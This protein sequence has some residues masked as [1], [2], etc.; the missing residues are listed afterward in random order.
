MSKLFVTSVSIALLV[1]SGSIHAD[2]HG[3]MQAKIDKL[4]QEKSFLLKRLNNS[5]AY[6]KSRAAQIVELQAKADSEQSNRKALS[7]R[8]NNAV[9]FSKTRGANLEAAQAMAD[10]EQR[11]STALSKRLSN[12]IAFSKTR[13]AKLEAAQAMADSEQRKS[14]ALSKRLSNAIA[15]SKTRGAK[16]AES[17]AMAESEKSKRIALSK[18]LSNAIAFSK[19]RAEHVEEL[20]AKV[21]SEQSMRMAL[22]KRLS[23][24]IS[25][26][27][28]RAAKIESLT[29]GNN[30]AASTRDSLNAAVGG[31][32]GTTVSA[33]DDDSVTIQVG[34]NGLFSAGGTALSGTGSSLLS[35]I[36]KE[37]SKVEGQL[38]VV[39]H[40]DNIPMGK[41][42]R[43][44]SNEALSFARAASTLQFL[45]NEGIPTERLAAAGH[46]ANNPIASNDTAEGRAQN[47]RVDIVLSQ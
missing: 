4:Q 23:N 5:I 24:A 39:G 8:L 28:T 14:M 41:G 43:Y 18:R 37:L 35:D 30:W 29:G 3:D 15:F 26:S 1:A 31:I 38:M 46:G 12:A 10:S 20:Q 25:F 33:N 6:S 16:L 19:T 45:Q 36:A 47:R 7:T 32:Q 2:S 9:S 44:S 17:Q 40:S 42:G 34:N 27:K 21:D 22:S 13:G 11:K